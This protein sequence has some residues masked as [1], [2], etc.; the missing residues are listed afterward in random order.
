MSKAWEERLGGFLNGET[1][2]YGNGRS[3]GTATANPAH[4]KIRWPSRSFTRQISKALAVAVGYPVVLPFTIRGIGVP[5][6]VPLQL[7]LPLQFSAAVWPSA[8]PSPCTQ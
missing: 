4:R 3:V 2:G 7:T 5:R 6:F 8:V 1:D